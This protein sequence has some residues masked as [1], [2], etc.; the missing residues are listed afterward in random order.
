MRSY[1]QAHRGEGMHR[2]QGMHG[3]QRMQQGQGSGGR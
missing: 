3:G 2:G 1:M